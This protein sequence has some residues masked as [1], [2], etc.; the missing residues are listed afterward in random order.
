VSHAKLALPQEQ[1]HTLAAMSSAAAVDLA[2]CPRAEQVLSDVNRV[3]IISS[4]LKGGRPAP[5]AAHRLCLTSRA[6]HA[7]VLASVRRVRVDAPLPVLQQMSSLVSL[8]VAGPG[9]LEP[10]EQPQLSCT[11][12]TNGICSLQALP[13]IMQLTKL[14]ELG[15]YIN[16]ADSVDMRHALQCISYLSTLS[17]LRIRFSQMEQLPATI[18]QLTALSSLDLCNCI[19]LQQLPAA[20]GQLAALTSL[21]LCDCI[22]LQ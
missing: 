17:S 9:R 2:G 5:Q 13:A 7:A 22:S 19:S 18:G 8:R 10:C 11:L 21:D 3:G 12:R 15:L 6:V 16:A 14:E 20:I 1:E 4:M